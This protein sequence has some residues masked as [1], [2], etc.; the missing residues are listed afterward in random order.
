MATDQ[1][2][3]DETLRFLGELVRTNVQPG[4]IFVLRSAHHFSDAG[5]TLLQETW[6]KHICEGA[7]YPKLLVLGPG[8]AL[9]V[10]GIGLDGQIVARTPVDTEGGSHD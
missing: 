5:A 1:P 10:F 8:M 2:I 3:S 9:E 7:P 4:D 6:T